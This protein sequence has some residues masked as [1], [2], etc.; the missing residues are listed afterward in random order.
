MYL[1][2]NPTART[3]F[4]LALSPSGLLP[5]RSLPVSTP[6]TTLQRTLIVL[7]FDSLDLDPCLSILFWFNRL[8]ISWF[9][10]LRFWGRC[11]NLEFTITSL[12][13]RKG[14]ED[15]LW[16]KNTSVYDLIF[17]KVLD[18]LGLCVV[19]LEWS[20]VASMKDFLPKFP[21][22]SSHF[23]KTLNSSQRNIYLFSCNLG[24][25]LR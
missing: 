11:R 20:L 17:P 2:H 16:V 18:R 6:N 5:H 14:D 1:C 3:L 24:Y 7:L 9:P 15:D 19:F 22:K 10:R 4:V 8:I 12:S 25:N 23:L 21:E 13:M